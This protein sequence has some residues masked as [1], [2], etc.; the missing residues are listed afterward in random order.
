MRRG[1]ARRLARGVR[2]LGLAALLLTALPPTAS[3]HGLPNPPGVPV[4]GYLFAW[5]AAIVLVASFVGLKALWRAPRLENAP[6][7]HVARLP[8]WLAPLCGAIGVASFAG[9]VYCGLAGTS[10]PTANL[11]P[12]VVYV[13]FWV[14]LVL[15]SI[16]L[17]D[18]FAAFNPWLA[19]A[20]GAGRL[21][22]LLRVQLPPPLPYPAR[23]G[24]WPAAL[25]LAGFAWLEL[26]SSDR[27]PATLALLALVYAACQLLGM[28]FYGTRP[29]TSRGDAFAVYFNLFSR[30]SVL[31]WRR[32]ELRRRPLLS[33]LTSLAPAPGTIA[34]VCV[35]IGSTSFDGLSATAQWR[36]LAPKLQH[37]FASLGVGQAAASEL[38]STVGLLAMIA[39]VASIYRLGIGGM[40]SVTRGRAGTLARDFAHTLV[41]IAA[42]YVLAHYFTFLLYRGQAIAAL[43]SDPL[44][45]GSDLFGTARATIDYHVLANSIVWYVQVLALVCGHVAGLV[46]AHDRALL[47]FRDRDQATRSQHWMLTVMVGYTGLGLWLLSSVA[48]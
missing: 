9:L 37:D 25:G 21:A 10:S 40:R 24:R 3:A 5:A 27:S 36:E 31:R 20:R 22:A 11:T 44:G 17:G 23:L 29:W 7:R 41:P 38:A 35:M 39:I 42:G 8:G 43:A 12:T 19:L 26:V 15:A 33:G 14:G 30:L 6:T 16:V 18:V 34:L 32:R 47:R 4:P 13:V 45:H 46:L 2:A 48:R 28:A 1:P